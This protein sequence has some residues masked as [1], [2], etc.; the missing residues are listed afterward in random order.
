MTRLTLLVL[1]A[2]AVACLVAVRLDGH[3]ASGV[4]LGF[5]LGAGLS[6]LSFLYTRH[7]LVTSPR[8]VMAAFVVGFLVKLAA[9]LV[10]ALAFRYLPAAA[11]RADWRSFVVA[12]GAAVALILPLGTMLAMRGRRTGARPQGVT[13]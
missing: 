9:L 13:A 8:R 7:T 6:G 10:G 12:Y 1:A 2:F 4:V 11:E 3:L 5:S